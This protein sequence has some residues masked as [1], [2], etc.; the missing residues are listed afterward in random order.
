M[1]EEWGLK[2][3]MREGLSGS[4]IRLLKDVR[5]PYSEELYLAPLGSC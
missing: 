3:G 2:E 4:T 1:A 5:C